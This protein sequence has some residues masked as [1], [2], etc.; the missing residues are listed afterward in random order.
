MSGALKIRVGL[1][2]V[3]NWARFGHLRVLGLL[4]EYELS[5]V[6]SRRKEAARSAATEYG[7]KHVAGSLDELVNHPEVD[8]VLVLT[9]A[10][11]H[12]EAV[13]AAI[14]AGKDV[15]CEWPLTPNSATSQ[16]LLRLADE[17]G[18]RTI[19]GLQREFAPA[20]RYAKDQ[21]AQGFIGKMRSVRMHVSV[22]AFGPERQPS[23]R[24]STPAENFMSSVSIFGAHFMGPLF[25]LV[26]RPLRYSAVTLNQFPQV[27][28]TDTGEVLPSTAP[29]QMM[30]T[31]TLENGAVFTVHIEGGKR[32]GSGVQIDITGHDGDLRITNVSAFGG[33][34][35]HYQV[36]G[37]NDGNGGLLAMPVPASYVWLPPSAIQT[38]AL[39]LGDLY[40]AYLL[41]REHGS[42]RVPSFNHAVFIQRL[43]EQ[44]T[45]QQA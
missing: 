26:G 28:I 37:A 10:Q 18:V 39:E 16:E 30:L 15:Y 24:W 7:I 35:E 29:D 31:G 44:A 32:N 14:A 42:H 38:G 34:D 36:S 6:Y 17:A 2:G 27:T 33:A 45:K 11:Q 22:S 41:D 8:L 21:I 3:G 20:L 23:I 4:P 1:V 43:L 40:A 12:E 19:I 5:A 25:S 13:R 9:T